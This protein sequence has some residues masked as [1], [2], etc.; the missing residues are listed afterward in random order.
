MTGRLAKRYARAVLGLAREDGTL[1]ATGEELNRA[2]ATFDE[3]RLRP[4]VLSPVIDAAA[5]LRTAAGVA[6][7]LGLSPTVRN[8]I[9]LLAERN[10]LAILPDL[11]RWYDS[12]LDD[13]LGRA[14]VAIRSATTLS[15]A[16]RN[17][18]IELARRLTGRQKILSATEVDAELLGGVVLD[19]GGTVYDGSLRTQLARLTKEMAEGG[20]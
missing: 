2:A 16:E 5:R 17:E 4:L 19:I 8:L 12:L 18:L 20:S 15:A 14:R 10:R 1:E 11:A 13:E 9:A 6:D 7:A 3:P